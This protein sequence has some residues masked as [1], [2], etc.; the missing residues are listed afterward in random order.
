MC[1]SVRPDRRSPRVVLARRSALRHERGSACMKERGL[2]S[3]VACFLRA[4]RA[5]GARQERRGGCRRLGS[6]RLSARVLRVFPSV[7]SSRRG[8]ERW[9][10]RLPRHVS[11]LTTAHDGIGGRG[12]VGL[13][14]F[15]DSQL[16][17]GVMPILEL[18]TRPCPSLTLPPELAR[19]NGSR[20]RVARSRRALGPCVRPRRVPCSCRAAWRCAGSCA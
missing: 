19:G 20:H 8:E 16:G 1:R 10:A 9:Q 17:A 3:L 2:S 18:A 7:R 6:D 11:A 12:R 5:L 15:D 4:G 14:Q 13:N